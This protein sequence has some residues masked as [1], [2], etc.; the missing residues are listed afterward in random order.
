MQN[1]Q[2]TDWVDEG[3][4]VAVVGGQRGEQVYVRAVERLTPTLIVLGNFSSKFRRKDLKEIGR[5]DVRTPAYEI[6]RLDDPSVIEARLR[7]LV[8]SVPRRMTAPVPPG[9]GRWEAELDRMRT[10][11]NMI[12]EFA[13][14]IK[15]GK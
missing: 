9:P 14:R 2:Q 7:Q 3:M 1:A 15:E 5:R 4:S 10:E 11:M 8:N 12:M 6:R 13:K